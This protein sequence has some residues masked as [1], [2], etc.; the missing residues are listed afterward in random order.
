IDGSRRTSCHTTTT[1]RSCASQR[2]ITGLVRQ[3]DKHDASNPIAF[4]RLS[5]TKSAADD[6][7]HGSEYGMARF[8]VDVKKGKSSV[9][10]V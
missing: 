6:T 10:S 8:T 5:E 4:P 7:P 9:K 2:R 3:R 1:R